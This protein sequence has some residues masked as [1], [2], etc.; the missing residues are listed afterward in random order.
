MKNKQKTTYCGCER[1]WLPVVDFNANKTLASNTQ[2]SKCSTKRIHL[3]KYITPEEQ[4]QNASTKF[5][6]R[7]KLGRLGN[8]PEVKTQTFSREKISCIQMWLVHLASNIDSLRRISGWIWPLIQWDAKEH[9]LWFCCLSNSFPGIE[10]IS[11]CIYSK[12]NLSANW[13]RCY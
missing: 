7:S 10:I 3:E 4:L 12:I 6:A 8:L 13:M 9:Y 11:K 2:N 1:K 5:E